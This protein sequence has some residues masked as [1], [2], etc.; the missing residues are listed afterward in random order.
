MIPLKKLSRRLWVGVDVGGSKVAVLVVDAQR[1][2]RGRATMPTDVSG[3]KRTLAS[4]VGAI[5]QAIQ[6]ANAH[7][8]EIA[9]IGLGI[10]GRVNP[11]TGVVQLAVNL[12]WNEL[13]VGALLESEL[14]APCFLENDVRAATSG[15]YHYNGNHT[16]QSMAYVSIGTGI[17]AGLIINGAL[18]RGSS[19]MAGEIGHM[20][21]D[22]HGPRCQ[23]GAH[24]CLETFAAGPAIARL[25]RQA[26][27]SGVATLLKDFDPLTAE[28]VY[29]AARQ[30]DAAAQAIV[31]KVGSYLGQALQW[32]VTAYDVER[33][34]LGGGVAR[35]GEAFWQPI[36]RELDRQRQ[37]S[38]L[39]S[40]MLASE[41]FHLLP[42]D[43]DAGIWGAVALAQHGLE[44]EQ[45]KTSAWESV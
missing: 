23:C 32:M 11:E 19:G 2:V 22:P 16:L 4:I 13:P 10:P 6:A 45:E 42:A 1:R 26:V 31:D 24:G 44:K 33:I 5:R 27:E 25:G 28:N 40:E 36:L 12:N 7:E 39:A 15:V 14:G 21:I 18:Y 35:A 34:V 3:P 8:D 20:V 37:A 43:Y 9:A 17:A 38:P 30:G 29:Q 41:M